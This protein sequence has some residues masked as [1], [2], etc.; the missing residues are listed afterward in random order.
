MNN[1]LQ[2]QL[3]PPRVYALKERFMGASANDKVVSRCFHPKPTMLRLA[4]RRFL[5]QRLP[6]RKHRIGSQALQTP[7]NL[8][9][10]AMPFARLA[11]AASGALKA[12]Q[13]RTARDELWRANAST[14]LGTSNVI[15]RSLT[16][17]GRR[18]ALDFLRNIL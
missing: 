10:L 18:R 1:T 14:V 16:G 3:N 9:D 8:N 2:T 6:V 7:R 11:L 13:R 5:R 12:D 17:R 15:R 4:H